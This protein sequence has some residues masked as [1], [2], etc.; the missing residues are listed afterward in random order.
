LFGGVLFDV[1][2][3]GLAHPRSARP[4]ACSLPRS[5]STRSMPSEP[6]P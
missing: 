1:A 3:L 6:Q 4:R 5:S 2:A